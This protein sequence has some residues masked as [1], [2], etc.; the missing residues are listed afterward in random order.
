MNIASSWWLEIG[1]YRKNFSGK[2]CCTAIIFGLLPTLWDVFSDYLYAEENQSTHG[3]FVYCFL[4]LPTLMILLNAVE[5]FLINLQRRCCCC[6]CGCSSTGACCCALKTVGQVALLTA[7]AAAVTAT[8]AGFIATAVNFKDVVFLMSIPCTM[9]IIVMKVIAVVVHGENM[10]RKMVEITSYESSYEAT[11]QILFVSTISLHSVEKPSFYALSAIASSLVVITKAGIE[12]LL[13]NN[14][15]DKMQS[16]S[17][18]KNLLLITKYFP[19]FLLTTCFRIVGLLAATSIE[20]SN[21][22]CWLAMIFA[23]L[24]LPFLTLVCAKSCHLICTKCC[25][26]KDITVTDMLRGSLG[27]LGGFTVWGKRGNR[28]IQL[29]M[30]LFHLFFHTPILV[31]ALLYP[32]TEWLSDPIFFHWLC[33]SGLF[34]GWMSLPLFLAQ[35][36]FAEQCHTCCSKESLSSPASVEMITNATPSLPSDPEMLL[37]TTDIEGTDLPPASEHNSQSSCCSSPGRQSQE[38]Q[39]NLT[40]VPSLVFEGS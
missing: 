24:V 39:E 10:R 31:Y 19:V 22:Y 33:I 16:A 3:G 1:D 37:P 2:K 20:I 28:E 34:A 27:S 8:A 9:Y 14:F 38:L 11:F 32:Q 40:S 21:E 29:G 18:A 36:H 13:T 12:N 7:T 4:C 25:Y 26:L 35:I 6:C 15:E 30:T 23:P 17:C 5:G